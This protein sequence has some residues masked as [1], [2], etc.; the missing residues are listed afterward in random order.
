MSDNLK[1][2]YQAYS[3]WLDEGAPDGYM[4]DR[5]SGLCY[6][7]WCW[8]DYTDGLCSEMKQQ[9]RKAGLDTEYPFDETREAYLECDNMHLNPRRVAW[10]KEHAK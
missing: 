1:A 9:F 4:F 10:V 3:E 8:S 6:N 2:F 7:L 5:L